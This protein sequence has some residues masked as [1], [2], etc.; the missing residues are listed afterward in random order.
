M[1]V[2]GISLRQQDSGQN[3]IVVIF[4]DGGSEREW[5]PKWD[6]VRTMAKVAALTEYTNVRGVKNKELRLFDEAAFFIHN[7][8]SWTLSGERKASDEC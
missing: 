2:K 4:D 1:Q 5:T 8:C 3:L 7:V 6:D